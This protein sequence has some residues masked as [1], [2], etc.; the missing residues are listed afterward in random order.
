MCRGGH[1]P[2]GFCARGSMQHGLGFPRSG[3]I[4][5]PDEESDPNPTR[6]CGTSRERTMKIH[7]HPASIHNRMQNL[8]SLSRRLLCWVLVERDVLPRGHHCRSHL[9]IQ[10][11]PDIQLGLFPPSPRCGK[12]VPLSSAEADRFI[13]P[14]SSRL[15][16]VVAEPTLPLPSLPRAAPPIGSRSGEVLRAADSAAVVSDVGNLEEPGIGKRWVHRVRW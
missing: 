5:Q 3:E 13:C 9:A 10:S 8:P 1:N 7:H 6:Y 11:H 12:H 2:E 15:F 4:S 16:R 14:A